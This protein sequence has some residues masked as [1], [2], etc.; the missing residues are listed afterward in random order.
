MKST[1]NLTLILIAVIAISG[2]KKVDVLVQPPLEA[3]FLFKSRATYQVSTPTT[4]FK[5]PVGVTKLSDVDRTIELTVTSPTGAEEG[6]HYSLNK[7]KLVIPAGKAID[8]VVIQGV[9]SQ[10]DAGRRDTLVI[11]I[12]ETEGIKGVISNSEF[13]LFVRNAC[14]ETEITQT[15]LRELLGSYLNTTEF[16]GLIDQVERGP[17]KTIINSIRQRTEKSAVIS[18]RNIYDND[19]P[20]TEEYDGW[21]DIRFILDWSNPNNRT[22]TLEPQSKIGNAGTIAPSLDGEDL[23]VQQFSGQVGTFSYCNQT[24]RLVFQLGLT[25]LGWFPEAYTVNMARE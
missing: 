9:F 4:S 20:D 15:T 13:R 24:L 25:N 12:K 14:K 23:S 7:S 17:H 16:W 18:V 5:L 22:V 1:F 2:C 6:T 11:K 3:H 10:Y 21:N 8:T 19:D